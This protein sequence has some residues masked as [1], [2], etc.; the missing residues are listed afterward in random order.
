MFIESKCSIRLLVYFQVMPAG[1]R[2]SIPPTEG[3]FVSGL[4]LHNALWDTTRSVL[5]MPSTDS[6]EEQQMPVFWLK[7]SDVGSAQTSSRLYQLY[8]CPVYCASDP[9]L[10]GERNI[11]VQFSL[12]SEQDPSMWQYQRVFLTTS[13]PHV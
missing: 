5:M 1:L 9:K 8:K 3:V 6:R 13:V 4:N 10:H 12:P 2:P 7:P 11:V